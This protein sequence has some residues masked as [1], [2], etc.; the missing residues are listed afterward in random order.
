MTFENPSEKVELM[1]KFPQAL[2]KANELRDQYQISEAS[3][4]DYDKYDQDKIRAD[5]NEVNRLKGT[6]MLEKKEDYEKANE[7]L[8]HVFEMIMFDQGE[9]AEWFGP[10]CY[11]IK[12]SDYDDYINK[13]D[14]VA[15]FEED[16]AVSR[17]GMALDVTFGHDISKKVDKIIS[18]IKQGKSGQVDYFESEVSDMRGQLLNVP[19][20]VVGADVDTVR[21]LTNMWMENSSADMAK[22]PVQFQFLDQIIR[23]CD[24]FSK[25]A[26][27]EGQEKIASSYEKLRRTVE[28]IIASKSEDGMTDE[29]VR[30][31]FMDDFELYFK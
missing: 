6:F 19:R 28:K 16:D 1:P 20:V 7:Q 29:G 30:D 12:T 17:M 5:I 13:I 9:S 23:Q 15:E 21:E 4:M 27:E 2:N 25:L 18:D 10:N 8:A 11:F 31:T 14:M 24:Y 3:F 26:T 22:H